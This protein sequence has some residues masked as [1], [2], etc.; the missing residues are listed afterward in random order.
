MSVKI[1]TDST[2]YLP[3]DYLS[4]Y[5][6]GVVSLNVVMD[7]VSRREVELSNDTF[8]EE[9]ARAQDMPKSSQPSLD[10]LTQV[11]ESAVQKGQ[12]V[13]AIFLSSKLSGTVTS[14]GPL[15]AKMVME[16]YP[17]RTIAVCD[18]LNTGMPMGFLAI[19][20]A[21]AAQAGKPLAEIEQMVNSLREKIHFV[22]CPDTLDYLRKGG[23][24]GGASALLG[25]L[26]QIKPI[27]T[28]KEG[29]VIVLNKVRSQKKAI[30]AIVDILMQDIKTSA[31]LGD[32]IVHHINCPEDGRKLAESLQIAL[33]H[34]VRIQSIGPIVGLH[35]GPGSI[36]IAYILK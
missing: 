18:S 4:K 12:D 28:V 19:E 25:N 7:G 26:L 2:A 21:K 13:L 20:A 36:G 3:E 8:Y 30:S 10:E 5:D 31:G 15:A 22:F 32:I 23:R 11:F 6:I 34:P 14:A 17:E 9:M 16:K 29:A 27:L 35:V 1:I 24:I 33:K